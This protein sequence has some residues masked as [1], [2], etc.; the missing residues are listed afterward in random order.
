MLEVFVSKKETVDRG[1]RIL[2]LHFMTM[3][4]FYFFACRIL[5]PQLGI[6]SMRPVVEVQSLNNWTTREF[7]NTVILFS[8]KIQEFIIILLKYKIGRE[9][10]K[11]EWKALFSSRMPTNKYRKVFDR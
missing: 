2:K 1:L 10:E 8:L 6:E 9:R 4:F 3:N 7:P 11:C 5:V